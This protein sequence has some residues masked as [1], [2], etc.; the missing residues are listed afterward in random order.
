MKK[1]TVVGA[2]NVG[3]TAAHHIVARQLG[4]V[5]LID[6]ADG[7]AAG[8]ALDI[9]QS[10]AVDGFGT[11]ITGSSDYANAADSDVVLITAGIARK[12]GMSRDDLLKTNAT[13]IRDIATQCL[14]YAPNAIFIVVTNPLD[15]M[16]WLVADIV[17]DHKRVMGMAG[18]LDASRYAQF[19][20]EALDCSIQDVRAMIL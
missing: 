7:L 19:I 2:G 16:T 10:A 5:C 15:V 17:Q 11:H 12:P 13:I 8:K 3:A 14:N 20:A 1:I 6:I 9:M 18:V 4:S